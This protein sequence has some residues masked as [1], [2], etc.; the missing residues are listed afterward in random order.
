[1]RAAEL[2]DKTPYILPDEK[3][4]GLQ[5]VE[6]LTDD[7]KATHR[8]QIIYVIRNDKP[9]KY[10]TDLGSSLRFPNPPL[11]I[12]SGL[13]HSVAEVLEMADDARERSDVRKRLAELQEQSATDKTIITEFI[14]RKETERKVAYNK[15]H[16]G[17]TIRV[18]RIGHSRKRRK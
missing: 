16:H 5:E 2:T 12:I 9:A 17:P 18:Q 1:M 13:E 10:V 11:N 15:S 14:E 7:F 6:L 8:Y 4:I 3:A